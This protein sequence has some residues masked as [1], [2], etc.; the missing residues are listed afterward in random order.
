MPSVD[1]LALDPSSS[2][3]GWAVFLDGRPIDAGVI[4][5]ASTDF[6]RRLAR[7]VR[8]VQ[9]VI[10]IHAPRSIAMEWNEG[11]PSSNDPKRRRSLKVTTTLCHGQG[12]LFGALMTRGIAVE[13]VGDMTW[14]SRE[15][16]NR[17][18]K[19]VRAAEVRGRYPD[20]AEVWENDPGDDA[21]DAVG[22]GEWIVAQR[23]AREIESRGKSLGV[24]Q[25]QYRKLKGIK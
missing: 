9:D 1:L 20:L 5:S 12:A 25:L 21:A 19:E 18:K 13:F 8:G 15:G 3:V 22:L 2:A 11:R 16:K 17:L 23:K 6:G 4:R 24:G 10:S 14:T 7:L